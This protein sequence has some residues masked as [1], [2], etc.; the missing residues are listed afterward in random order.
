MVKIQP[1]WLTAILINNYGRS[2]LILD[3]SERGEKARVHMI[4]RTS[5]VKIAEW[6][7]QKTFLV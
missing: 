5:M 2:Y 1:R 3:L 6:K 7:K 4:A